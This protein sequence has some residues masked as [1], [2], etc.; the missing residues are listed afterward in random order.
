[1][2]ATKASVWQSSFLSWSQAYLDAG[3]DTPPSRSP[4]PAISKQAEQD[5]GRIGTA[6]RFTVVHRY[7]ALS[8]C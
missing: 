5:G 6:D 4:A 1:M 7:R 3:R 2:P 8:P